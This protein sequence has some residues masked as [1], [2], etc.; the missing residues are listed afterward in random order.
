MAFKQKDT[1]SY[2]PRIAWKVVAFQ[3]T[4]E[5]LASWKRMY[6]R[7]SG[8]PKCAVTMGKILAAWA[9]FSS[10]PSFPVSHS[11][12]LF[13]KCKRQEDPP[14]HM[15]KAFAQGSSVPPNSIAMSGITFERE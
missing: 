4:S 14:M 10:S 8:T 7:S 2:L 12:K 5:V 6:M 1:R 11:F 13:E 9:L 3:A 15:K